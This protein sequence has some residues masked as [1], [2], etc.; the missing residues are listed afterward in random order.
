MSHPLDRPIWSSLAT[1]HA[2]FR[3]GG[4]LAWRYP[5]EIS[6]FVVA[7]DGSAEAVAEMAGLIGAG[8]D[9]SLVEA[10]PPPAP[11]GFE[12]SEAVLVQMTAR[13]L[14]APRAPLPDPEIIELGDDDAP[15]MLALATLTRPGPFRARTHRLGRFLGVRKD[16]RLA[17]MC[18]ERLNVDGFHEL[19]ALCTHPD[20]RGK[21]LGE[22][23]FRVVAERI[24][25]EGDTVFLHSY[26]SNAPA[27]ALY[28]RLGFE[29]RAE[30]IHAMWRRLP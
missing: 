24:L 29:P 2:G 13:E 4:D 20:E 16:G 26:A 15:E 8:D 25:S 1:R 21:G 30:V 19:S 7:R 6:P 17:A 12:A 11:A 27:V 10:A 3:Q 23:L 18:G 9:A 14:A 28:R 22:A 5:A